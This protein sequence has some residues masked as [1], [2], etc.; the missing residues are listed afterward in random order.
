MDHIGRNLV[1][2]RSR[3]EL[4]RAA[5][6]DANAVHVLQLGLSHLLV[7]GILLYPLYRHVAALLEN[8]PRH[9]QEG[10]QVGRRI[11]PLAA[12]ATTADGEDLTVVG[13][14]PRRPELALP[15]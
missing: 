12:A 13:W 7:D 5:R 6:T 10:A 4:H 14:R 8:F 2:D 9:S 11:G 3:H 1:A 15:A